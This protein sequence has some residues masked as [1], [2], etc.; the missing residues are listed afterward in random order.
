[1]STDIFAVPE[2]PLVAKSARKERSRPAETTS[3]KRKR[4][5]EEAHLSSPSKK[6]R[7]HSSHNEVQVKDSQDAVDMG[8]SQQSRTTKH[9]KARAGHLQRSS[10]ADGPTPFVRQSFCLYL[11][12]SPIAMRNP[13][14]GLCAEHL[15]PLILTYYPPFKGVVLSYSNARLIPGPTKKKSRSAPIHAESIA[16][17]AVSFAWVA[18]DFL[19][20]RPVRGLWMEGQV[21]VQNKSHLGLIC[22][23]MFNASL[24]AERLPPGWSFEAP[25]DEDTTEQAAGQGEVDG[26]TS[27]DQ[28]V[29][30]WVDEA[31]EKV[32]GVI[33]FRVSD[34]ESLA[35]TGGKD[36]GFLSITGTLLSEEQDLEV[37]RMIEARKKQRQGKKGKA[38]QRTGTFTF[39]KDDY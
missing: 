31:G 38:K 37:D 2:S 20:L 34:T 6:H 30:T 8:D 3:A 28:G 9:K 10:E 36:R 13:L 12:L 39:D 35:A 4:H 26:S 21:N 11:P 22:Y 33:R 19:L 16:E 5:E 29:G 1:M 18:A 14:E 17:Y 27:Q 7:R 32:N 24:D 23:N 15:S 25:D